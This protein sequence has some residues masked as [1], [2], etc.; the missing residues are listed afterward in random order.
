MVA[1]NKYWYPYLKLAKELKVPL[2]HE[3]QLNIRLL[4]HHCAL[5]NDVSTLLEV[6]ERLLLP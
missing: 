2:H 1:M 3:S 6:S 5:P 4:L